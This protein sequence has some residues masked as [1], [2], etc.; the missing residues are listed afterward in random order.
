[1]DPAQLHE[2]LDMLLRKGF[3]SGPMTPTTR[4]RKTSSS[5]STAEDS[6]AVRRS[7]EDKM[8]QSRAEAGVTSGP[9]GCQLQRQPAHKLARYHP[10]P[11]AQPDNNDGDDTSSSVTST[12]PA[13]TTNT[14]SLTSLNSTVRDT[15]FRPAEAIRNPTNEPLLLRSARTSTILTKN[16]NTSNS[17]TTTTTDDCNQPLLLQQLHQHTQQRTTITKRDMKRSASISFDLPVGGI[18]Q[19]QRLPMQDPVGRTSMEPSEVDSRD[20]PSSTCIT[21]PL[22]VVEQLPAP[23]N[24]TTSNSSSSSSSTT[25]RTAAPATTILGTP[26]HLPHPVTPRQSVT[27]KSHR[28]FPHLTLSAYRRPEE[29]VR[30][31]DSDPSR[32]LEL[33]YD[34]R[35]PGCKVIGHGA[36]STVRSAVRRSDRKTV[37][38]KSISKFDAM[39]ARRLRRPGSKHMDEWEIMRLLEKNP[40]TLTLFDIFETDEDIHLVTEFCEGGELFDAIK[41]K[42]T[43]R[44]SFRRGRFSEPQAARITYQILSALVELHQHGIVHRD[45][46]PENILMMKKEEESGDK[47]Q[48]KLCDFGV[49]RVHHHHSETSSSDTSST[50][51]DGESSP[52]TPGLLLADKADPPPE[53]CRGNCGPAADMFSMGV[54]L[55]ILLCGFPPVFCE[56][57]VQFP[58]AYWQEMSEEA[59][60]VVRSMLHKEPLQRIS[61]ANALKKQW[62]REQNQQPSRCRR[63]SISA[64][65]ELVRTQLAKNLGSAP[66]TVVPPSEPRKNNKRSLRGSS[67]HFTSPKRS[68]RS[69]LELPMT[70]LY[71]C[72]DKRDVRVIEEKVESPVGEGMALKVACT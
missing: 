29:M 9:K 2:R 34:L 43:T 8:H 16:N 1:M 30:L 48:V 68:K 25:R 69:P 27:K 64:N 55:Y 42:G 58:E 4:K 45:I 19:H 65:L 40:Y 36:Y 22:H 51:S 39:R 61:A 23:T 24:T 49:A 60:D 50:A 37:A 11:E 13:S 56:N 6:S 53:G 7:H 21:Q 5:S 3:N 54:T 31:T 17:S 70:D 12:M 57:V 46:K 35:A 28:P 18:K 10:H 20:A 59:K 14:S 47:I 41:R 38:I 67:I 72:Q 62:I 15:A 32:K 52:S 26:S 44:S 71:T 33:E 66:K 63:G